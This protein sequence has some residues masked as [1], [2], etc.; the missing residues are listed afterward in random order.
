VPWYEPTGVISGN[1]RAFLAAVIAICDSNAKNKQV[2]ESL[3]ALVSDAKPGV[4]AQV[5]DRGGK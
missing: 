1:D 4:K 2:L 5:A 3:Q